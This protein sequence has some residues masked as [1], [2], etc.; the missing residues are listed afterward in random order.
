MEEV[1]SALHPQTDAK[2][3]RELRAENAR[4][5]REQSQMNT[6]FVVVLILLA[7]LTLSHIVA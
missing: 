3:L 5:K 1:V 6:A 7:M 4:L 2:E